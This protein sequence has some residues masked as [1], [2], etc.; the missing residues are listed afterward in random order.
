MKMAVAIF[1][2][3][4]PFAC[5]ASAQDNSTT[6]S[7]SQATSVAKG[8]GSTFINPLLSA[9]AT[10][11]RDEAKADIEYQP[12]GSGAGVS[13][14]M[15][16]SV[17]FGATDQPLTSAELTQGNLVQFPIAFGAIVPVVNLMGVKPGELR[18]SGPVLADI[19]GGKVVTWDDP[20]IAKLNPS[21]KLPKSPII[22]VYRADSSGTTFNFTHYLSQVSPSWK[23]AL[24]EGKTVKWP[25]GIGASSNSS[26]ADWVGRMPNSIG[27]VEYAYVLTHGLTYAC[28]QNSRGKLVCPSTKSFA[29]AVES[30][31]W[32]KS[33]DFDLMFTNAPGAD[34]Y[35][36]VA[37]TF[38]LMLVKPKD[39]VR[40]DAALNFFRYA[41][42]KGRVEAGALSYLPLPANLVPQVETYLAKRD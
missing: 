2:L 18:L 25:T 8:A 16:G 9:W 7:A 1:L 24:G 22:I 34:A 10:V 33:P 28:M 15:S 41:L 42:E 29:S 19:F 17:D 3:L 11:Y 32:S 27:Y 38:I 40:A 21:L 20:A 35:P 14:L 4:A 26:V 12:V 30:T 39:K 5:A 36:I 37:A 23:A 31:D 13:Q 6:V